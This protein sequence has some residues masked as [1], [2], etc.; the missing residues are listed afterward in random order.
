MNTKEKSRSFYRN[1][2]IV[3]YVLSFLL[4]CWVA[5]IALYFNKN[6]REI[7]DDLTHQN[8][9]CCDDIDVDTESE[10]LILEYHNSRV[11][12]GALAV[13]ITSTILTFLA[14]Y[15]QYAFNKQQRNDISEER[16]ENQ[17]FHLLDVYRGICS[18]SDVDGK[19]FGK[20]AFHYMF[21][22]YKAI[23]YIISEDE[24][25]KA[26]NLNIYDKNYLAFVFFLNGITP[27]ALPTYLNSCL[28]EELRIKILLKVREHLYNNRSHKKITYLMDYDE[29]NIMFADG[30]RP[31]FI[32]YMKYVYLIVEYVISSEMSD[33]K[34]KNYIKY[35][36]S[37]M[38]D[39]EIGLLYAYKSYQESLLKE[40]GKLQ[41]LGYKAVDKQEEFNNLLSCIFNNLPDDIGFKFRF[42]D[43]DFFNR[44]KI[45]I[46]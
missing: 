20:K 6:T 15:I 19:I 31:V 21:Y 10:G 1:N 5:V 41:S 38:S 30:H 35:L 7:C 36:T 27:N 14:F 44:V 16:K 29:K 43:K 26:L 24:E 8:E 46:Q 42:D 9:T 11:N 22:E 3:V 17:F 25:I 34:R 40:S 18:N 39:H 45:D 13:A 37:E 33:K 2:N 12:T 32:P 4:F 28:S 23:F